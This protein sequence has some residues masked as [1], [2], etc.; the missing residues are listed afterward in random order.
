MGNM[1]QIIRGIA[2]VH[3]DPALMLDAADRALRLEHPE[4][5]VSAFVGVL[6]PIARTFAYASAG[7]PPPMLR[8]PNGEV[9]L[10]SDNGLLLG[11]RHKTQES[12]GKTITIPDGS[13]LVFYTD[14]LTE[15]SRAPAEGEE[16]LADA[17]REGSVLRELH[18]ASS[19]RDALIGDMVAKDDVAILVMGI[20]T[21]SAPAQKAEL[22]RRWMFEAS[23]AQAGGRARREFAKL[24][25]SLGGTYEQVHAAEV[26]FGELAGNAARHASGS[27][28]AVVDFSGPAPVL[29]VLDNG[30][31]FHYIPA[32]PADVYS[33][34]GRGLY[35][36][37]LLSEDFHVSRRPGGGSHARAVLACHIRTPKSVTKA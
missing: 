27:I 34:S 16:A 37:S 35:L 26:V 20:A 23:D 33:E 25:T 17:L 36:I 24:L 4:Q 22:T 13:Y 7:H 15:S 11:L 10:L 12:R 5:L 18:P 14:G 21:G 28:E 8:Y 19:L 31:G 30:S 29:H 2:Q 6:D 9:A 3:A 1:R 32:L